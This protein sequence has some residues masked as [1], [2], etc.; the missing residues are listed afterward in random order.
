MIG[1]TW[2]IAEKISDV[3]VDMA[4]FEGSTNAQLKQLGEEQMRQGEQLKQPGEQ[5]KQQGEQLTQLLEL[6]QKKR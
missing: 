2:T 4:R 5:L 3:R 6:A 1:G